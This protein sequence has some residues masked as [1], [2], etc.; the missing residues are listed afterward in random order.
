M[1]R[2]LDSCIN[3]R[4]ISIFR[5]DVLHIAEREPALINGEVL[6]IDHIVDISP[7]SI[8]RNAILLIV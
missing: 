5:K 7:N 3:Y 4:N 2:S 1:T 6:V 8:E